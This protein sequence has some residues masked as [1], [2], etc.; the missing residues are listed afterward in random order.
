[1]VLSE[2]TTVCRAAGFEAREGHGAL[3]NEMIQ[4]VAAALSDRRINKGQQSG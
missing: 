4:K 1:M 2:T 3:K